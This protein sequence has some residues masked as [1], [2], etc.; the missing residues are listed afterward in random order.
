MSSFLDIIENL[1]NVYLGTLDE[2][3]KHLECDN[4]YSWS[5]IGKPTIIERNGS[6]KGIN[7]VG[8]TEV[9]KHF[10][11]I[12]EQYIKDE[13]HNGIINSTSV[14]EFLKRLLK[15]DAERG[16]RKTIVILD[17]ARFHRSKAVKE[18]AKE[19]SQRLILIFQPPY[20]PELNPQENIWNWMKKFIATATAFTSINQLSKSIQDF[21][22]YIKANVNLVKRRVFARNYYKID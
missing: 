19:N 20:W 12:Y 9:L 17:N 4:Y 14:I 6:K 13:H 1:S 8:A 21:Q 3:G 5:P 15:Y 10:D 11:F 2:T 16:I 7:I 18:F 22:M